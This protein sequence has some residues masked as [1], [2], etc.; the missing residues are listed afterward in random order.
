MLNIGLL[1]DFFSDR[2]TGEL[3]FS[4]LEPLL[5]VVNVRL[6]APYLPPSIEVQNRLR[7]AAPDCRVVPWSDLAQK[8]SREGTSIDVLNNINTFEIFHFIYQDSRLLNDNSGS[9]PER[10]YSF[11]CSVDFWLRIVKDLHLTAVY[12]LSA[13]HLVHDYAFY[14]ACKLA[15][16]PFRFLSPISLYPDRKSILSLDSSIVSRVTSVNQVPLTLDSS[17]I[18]RESRPFESYQSN[19][20]SVMSKVKSDAKSYYLNGSDVLSTSQSDLQAYLAA[21]VRDFQNALA[22]SNRRIKDLADKPIILQSLHLQPEATTS[23][24]GLIPEQR[25]ATLQLADLFPNSLVL[26]KE[27]PIQLLFLTRNRSHLYRSN[28]SFRTPGF[29]TDLVLS[30]DNVAF[31]S[32]STSV[33]QIL[34]SFNVQA[35]STYSGSPAI[36]GILNRIPVV[37]FGASWFNS[38]PGCV[39][40]NNQSLDNI[41]DLVG[42][43]KE[44][45]SSLEKVEVTLGQYIVEHSIYWQFYATD[46]AAE[47]SDEIL[48]QSITAFKALEESILYQS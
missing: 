2:A 13:P 48:D 6:Y 15:Q 23:S 31:A 29:Y 45:L 12:S 47:S 43:S 27:H 5:S 16:V 40:L 34:S 20:K 24:S 17:K 32:I 38:F 33:N 46:R 37:N 41:T 25:M 9:M 22:I 26:V 28:S 7:K 14:L 44:Y 21:V 19:Y 11:L 42:C 4:I 35:V 3:P 18:L 8:Y 39:P 30:R 10:T 36:N 1:G